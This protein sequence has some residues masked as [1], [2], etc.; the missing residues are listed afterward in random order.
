M[1]APW[2]LH[3]GRWQ[4][5]L[6]GVEPDVLI[7]DAPYGARTHESEA[8]RNDGVD[9]AGLAPEYAAWSPDHVHEYVRSWS[10]R[11][12]GWMVTMTS[13][14]LV[15]AFEAAF[16]EADRYCFA[17]VIALID[18]MTV[19]VRGDGPSSWAIHIMVARLKTREMSNY[20]TLPGGY[21]GKRQAGAGGGRG[22]PQWLCNALVRDYSRPGNV[23]VD[24]MA[25]WGTG[26]EA[27]L[28]YGRTTIG[29]E[30]DPVA[31]AEAIRRLRRGVQSDMF[32]ALA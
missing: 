20:G 2:T 17:P 1:S 32:G 10:P 23:V 14:D 18:G 31:H 3:L 30:V 26:L 8:E 12:K 6:D 22:K 9:E 4:D 29:C 13:H 25:G 28:C 21:H 11:T 27:A 16:A 19:R 7:T 5:K 15:P 24:P